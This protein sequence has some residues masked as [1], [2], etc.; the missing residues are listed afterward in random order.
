MKK[1]FFVLFLA[2]FLSGCATVYRIRFNGY[3]SSTQTQPPIPPGTSFYV[4][5]DKN[6]RNSIFEAEIKSKIES[7]LSQKGYRIVPYEQADFHLSFIYSMS[8]GRTVTEI[9]PV[10]HSGETGAIQTYTSTGKTRTSYITYPGYTT[11]I[12]QEFTLYT[13]SLVLEVLDANLFRSTKEEKKVWIGE[14]TNTSG[15]P[16]LREAVNYLL[17]AAFGHFGENTHKSMT[18][19]VSKKNPQLKKLL[20]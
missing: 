13:S 2:L 5:E 19:D 14:A 11:Y 8:S 17:I 7:L 15:D 20:Q 1:I 6:A 18:I 12:P 3:L 9:T 10:Y 4:V 16:D